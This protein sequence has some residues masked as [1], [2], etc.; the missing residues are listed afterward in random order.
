MRMRI[1][2]QLLLQHFDYEGISERE[3]ARIAGLSHTTI[4]NYLNGKRKTCNAASAKK[5][6]KALG[7]PRMTIFVP[8]PSLV[9]STRDGIAA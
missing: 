9:E 7:A 3:L 5:I 6:E 1:R 8:E 2:R 4:Q